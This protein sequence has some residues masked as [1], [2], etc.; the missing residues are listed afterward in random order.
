MNLGGK[1]GHVDDLILVS[2]KVYGKYKTKYNNVDE[3]IWRT[4]AQINA[5]K[6]KY[7]N[8]WRNS[9]T[10]GGIEIEENKFEYIEKFRY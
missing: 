9:D 4:W 10:F 8:S 1:V 6:T 5:D 7:M 2:I 3:C